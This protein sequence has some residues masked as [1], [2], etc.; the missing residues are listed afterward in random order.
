M[1]L[2]AERFLFV[3]KRGR[4][5]VVSEKESLVSAYRNRTLLHVQVQYLCVI[6][7]CDSDWK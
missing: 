7:G 6:L 3:F 5:R 1:I 2:S 4:V